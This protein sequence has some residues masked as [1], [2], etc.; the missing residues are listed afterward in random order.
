MPNLSSQQ[1]YY[2]AL[3]TQIKGAIGTS[4]A[5]SSKITDAQIVYAK[6]PLAR[7]HEAA[8]PAC[9]VSPVPETMGRGTNA[10]YD[11]NYSA[12]VT[13][14]QSSNGD[15]TANSD[16]LLYWRQVLLDLFADRRLT[17]YSAA[18]I[19]TIEP[20]S[21]F[22]PAAWRDNVDVSSF[23]VRAAVRRTNR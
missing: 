14:I 5:A 22:S 23:V 11:V 15:L 8:L 6:H 9:V 20:G 10:S 3:V 12:R 2:D 18:S 13:L 16:R 4:S 17:G 1:N 19:L 7:S 21:P